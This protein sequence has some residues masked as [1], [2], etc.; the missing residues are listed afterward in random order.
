METRAAALPRGV[1]P[2]LETQMLPGIHSIAGRAFVAALSFALFVGCSGSGNAEGEVTPE[3]PV[4]VELAEVD[5]AD[6]QRGARHQL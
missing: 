5:I 3:A 6:G 4:C 1:P 2:I